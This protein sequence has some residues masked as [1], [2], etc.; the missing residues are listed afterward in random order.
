MGFTLRKFGIY[1]QEISTIL[2]LE[3]GEDESKST[4]LTGKQGMSL[5]RT[6]FPR[7]R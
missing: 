2:K 6:I 5:A 7:G 3:Q 1:M 4:S